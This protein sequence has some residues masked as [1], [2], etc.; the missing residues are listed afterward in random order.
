[1]RNGNIFGP[2]T[3]CFLGGIFENGSRSRIHIEIFAFMGVE[4]NLHYE[5]ICKL[6]ALIGEAEIIA[7][8]FH[9]GEVNTQRLNRVHKVS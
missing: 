9:L 8:I 4:S 1:M 2:Q 7:L 6:G 3:P 5:N